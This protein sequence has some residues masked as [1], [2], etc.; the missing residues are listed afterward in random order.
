MTDTPRFSLQTL[1]R[2]RWV[3][4]IAVVLVHCAAYPLQATTDFGSVPWHWSNFYDAA[5]RWCVP[6]FVMISGALLLDPDRVS[7][8]ASFYRRRAARILP[9]LLFWSVF[10]L[11]WS[12][13]MH[14]WQQEPLGLAAWLGKLLKGAPYYHLWYLYMI[15]GLYLFAPF[16]QRLYQACSDRA[17]LAALGAMLLCAAADAAYR[18]LAA[19]GRPGFFFN[20][21][22]PYTAYFLAG[23]LIYAQTL[24][25]PRPGLL[26]GLSIGLSAL[27]VAVMSQPA[28]LDFYFYDAFN[29]VVILMSLAAFQWLLQTRALPR[30][31]VL[32]PLTFGVYLLHPVF[33]DVAKTLQLYAPSQH[34]AWQIPLATA[35]IVALS[36]GATWLMRRIPLLR[37]IT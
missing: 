2:A 15:V 13:F 4:A 11:G 19:D 22:L 24:K 25:V 23:R 9:A 32:A 27:G 20:A 18:H 16:L 14:A 7:G 3:A 33:L 5:A 30:L 1:D 37:Q 12:A 6:V 31:S 29:P 10:Y 35:G 28:A 36:L 17:R 21:F 8:L 34:A 26:F